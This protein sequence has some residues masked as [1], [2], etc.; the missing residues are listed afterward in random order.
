MCK[1]LG[2]NWETAREYAKYIRQ[3]FKF[4]KY[5]T[6]KLFHF[7]KH[8]LSELYCL[9]QVDQLK[10]LALYP[11]YPNHTPPNSLQRVCTHSPETETI[12]I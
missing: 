10:L 12:P 2:V 8:E 9:P 7:Q 6:S 11:F 1:L 4:N 5:Q 3:T